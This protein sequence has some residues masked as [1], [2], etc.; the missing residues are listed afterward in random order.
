LQNF[1]ANALRYTPEGGVLVGV[2]WR[3]A[4]HEPSARDELRIDVVDTGVGIEP[5][6]LDAVFVEFTRLGT[7]EAEGLG[8]GLALS[9]A[10]RGCWARGSCRPTPAGAAVSA[11]I[12]PR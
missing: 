11:S 10:S 1:I 9:A 3:R 12:C 2:R 5:D 7:V 6:K 8:L 4:G